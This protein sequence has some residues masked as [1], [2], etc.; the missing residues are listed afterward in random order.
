M[1]DR[2]SP[3]PHNPRLTRRRH[4]QC[5]ARHTHLTVTRRAH[6]RDLPH[7]LPPAEH[8]QDEQ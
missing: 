7:K 5:P 6:P 1:T 2:A 8:T 3:S 4:T